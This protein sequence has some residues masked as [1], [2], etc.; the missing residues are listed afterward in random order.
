M[1]ALVMKFGGTSVGSAAAVQRSA[2]LAVQA[3]RQSGGVIVVVSALSGV[4]NLLLKAVQAAQA[5]SWQVVTRLVGEFSA[6]HLNLLASL[7]LPRAAENELCCLIA[8]QTHQLTAICADV[9]TAGQLTGEQQDAAAALGELSS[10]PLFAAQ[11]TALGVRAVSVD[12]RRL[13]ITDDKHTQANVLEDETGRRVRRRLLPLVAGE[14]VPVVTGYIGGTLAGVTTTLGR[15]ASDYTSAVIG[16]ALQAREVWN[17]TDVPGVMSAD[18]QLVPAARTLPALSYTQMEHMAACGAKVLHA[19][20]TRPLAR[21]GIPLRVLNSFHP[22]QPGTW[23]GS[24]AQF[25]GTQPWSVAYQTAGAS[26][27]LGRLSRISVLGGAKAARRAAAI[28]QAQHIH[29]LG[30]AAQ[31]A[32]SSTEIAAFLVPEADCGKAVRLLHN[33]LISDALPAIPAGESQADHQRL[34]GFA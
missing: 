10:A 2:G 8:A 30:A 17:W 33:R 12:A 27:Y 22:E 31:P 19:E 11:L 29:V 6:R 20:T 9:H 24:E 16:A 18:P 23:V 14:V 7:R 5:R 28:L 32:A 25:A 26:P 1:Q 13:L 34:I 4:T 21:L 3:Q 15:G